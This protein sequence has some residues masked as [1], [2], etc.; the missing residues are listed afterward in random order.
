MAVLGAGHSP[1]ISPD[2][3]NRPP[4]LAELHP[5]AATLSP[6]PPPKPLPL[7]TAQFIPTS[8]LSSTYRRVSQGCPNMS[9][10]IA[11]AT[12]TPELIPMQT[13]T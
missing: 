7:H 6:P 3:V 4:S 8:S 5:G 1:T 10:D 9:P 13:P 11:L 12:P 2:V